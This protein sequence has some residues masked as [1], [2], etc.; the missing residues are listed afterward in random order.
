MTVFLVTT[1]KRFIGE[2]FDTKITTEVPPGSTFY[3]TDTKNTAIYTGSAW[4]YTVADPV[5]AIRAAQAIK[6][7]EEEEEWETAYIVNVLQRVGYME[8]RTGLVYSQ[9]PGAVNTMKFVEVVGLQMDGDLRLSDG[10][11]I[12]DAATGDHLQDVS[13]SDNI[14]ITEAGSRSIS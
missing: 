2:S 1:I 10:I 7:T 4:V 14:S 11:R 13:I 5:F 12:V 3:E 8:S 6:I 9:L